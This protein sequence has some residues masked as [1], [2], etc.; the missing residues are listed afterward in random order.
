MKRTLSLILAL[1]MALSLAAC[2]KKDDGK[3]DNADAP[4]DSLA[5]LTKVWDSY[6][7]DEKFPAAGG[8]YETS[9]DDAPGAFDPSNADNLNFL[10]TVPT[11]DASLIDDA[12]SLMHM[13]NANTFT[14]GALRVKNGDDAAKLAEDLRD[15]IQN[16][17]WMCGFPDKLVIATLG[18]YVVSVYG[19]EEL[20]NTFRDKLQAAFSDAAI[21][22]DE[23]IGEGEFSDGED[24]ALE[25]PVAYARNNTAAPEPLWCGRCPFQMRSQPYAVFQYPLPFL[26]PAL[27]VRALFPCTDALEKYRAAARKPVLLRLGR[28]EIRC[29]HAR[30]H[31]AGLCA[32]PTGGEIPGGPRAREALSDALARVQSGTSGLL[33]V[34]GLL[35]LRL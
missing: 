26:F 21:A 31:R 18:N 28:A 3:A 8:D 12:A 2:G 6:T 16:K 29:F 19:D 35:P 17:Q 15:A 5:L 20:V 13:M 24:T 4:A 27:R 30:V 32:C 25:A 14:C 33:Q 22:Y 23:M 7:D 1:V 11:E 34:R 10:L 9:V